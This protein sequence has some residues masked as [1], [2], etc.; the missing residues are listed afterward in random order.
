MK[1]QK[2]KS[3]KGFSK[4]HKSEIKKNKLKIQYNV[5][6]FNNYHSNLILQMMELHK[7]LAGKQTRSLDSWLE[8]E[9]MIIQKKVLWFVLNLVTKSFHTHF[10]MIT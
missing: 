8:N 5:I 7:S 6:N 2:K 9:K 10:F 1:V 3:L 4:G